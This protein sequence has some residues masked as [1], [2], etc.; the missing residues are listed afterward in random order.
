M[1]QYLVENEDLTKKELDQ[2]RNLV[3]KSQKP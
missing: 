1:M 3:N 2:L